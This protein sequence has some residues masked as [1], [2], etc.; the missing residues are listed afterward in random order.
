V[1]PVIGAIS[2]ESLTQ[3]LLDT[4]VRLGDRRHVRL[5]VHD[6]VESPESLEG[7]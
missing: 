3:N 1:N 5:G 2:F 7:Q 4:V 6:E